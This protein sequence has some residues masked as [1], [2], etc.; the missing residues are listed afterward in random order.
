MSASN[1][2]PWG[3]AGNAATGDSSASYFSMKRNM[4]LR[5]WSQ[6]TNA[7]NASEGVAMPG[8]DREASERCIKGEISVEPMLASRPRAPAPPSGRKMS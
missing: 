3:T 5:Y 1:E 4:A 6:R 7:P 8:A 2:L